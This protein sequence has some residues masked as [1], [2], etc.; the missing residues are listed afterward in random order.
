MS[1]AYLFKILFHFYVLLSE[2]TGDSYCWT[3]LITCVLLHISGNEQLSST[4]S[5]HITVLDINDNM[6]TLSQDYQ[7]YV[8]EDTQAGEV[9]H[10]QRLSFLR[11]RIACSFC[12]PPL[13]TMPVYFCEVK[14]SQKDQQLILA[15]SML[16]CIGALKTYNTHTQLSHSGLFSVSTWV[17]FYIKPTF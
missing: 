15:C 7:P 13:V 1:K 8:C 3:K 16:D 14:K 12:S 9:N 17:D 2:S 11:M 5:L 10:T 4:V 6:P